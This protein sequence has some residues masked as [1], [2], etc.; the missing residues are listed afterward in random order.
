MNTKNKYIEYLTNLNLEKINFILDQYNKG[1]ISF[2]ELS[3]TI[4]PVIHDVESYHVFN[5]SIRLDIITERFIDDD[6]HD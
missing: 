4:N 3:N 1:I 5:K 6:I 2:E